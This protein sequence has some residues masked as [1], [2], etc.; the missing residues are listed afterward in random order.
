MDNSRRAFLKLGCHAAVGGLFV[1]TAK[2]LL[3]DSESGTAEAAADD[4]YGNYDPSAHHWA[5]LIDTTKCI[6][7][8]RCARACKAENNV[9]Y[10]ASCNRTWIS[11]TASPTTIRST[12]TR[13][14]VGSTASIRRPQ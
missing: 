1:I 5:F 12:S 3:F 8:G 14:R 10:E 7:C 4:A 11:A 2:G 6:G 13:R 9:P